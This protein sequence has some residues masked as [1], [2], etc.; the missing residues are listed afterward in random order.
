MDLLK[1]NHV[2]FGLLGT[3]IL[4]I[5][6][7][8]VHTFAGD[9]SDLQFSFWQIVLILI[10]P[11]LL[12]YFGIR[13]KRKELNHSLSYKQGIK[14]GYKIALVFALSSPFVFLLYFLLLNFQALTSAG[15]DQIHAPSALSILV[16]MMAQ[17]WVS[18]ALGTIYGIIATL[19]L[20]KK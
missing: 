11:L 15:N 9:T 14:E 3:A 8:F 16:D 1:Q 19:L 10:V 7:L 2:R 18:L 12:W 4:T 5:I 6:L 13:A 17:F 20:Q